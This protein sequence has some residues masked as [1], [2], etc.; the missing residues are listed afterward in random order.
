MHSR[1]IGSA[2]MLNVEVLMVAPP[3]VTFI[4]TLS[5]VCEVFP[6]FLI[7]PGVTAERLSAENV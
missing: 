2:N 4:S 7:I 1:Q 5:E 6:L 3:A